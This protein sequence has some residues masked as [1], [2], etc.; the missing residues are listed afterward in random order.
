MTGREDI[1]A[2]AAKAFQTEPEHLWSQWPEHA[3]LRHAESG[4]WYGLIMTL[5]GSTLG[6]EGNAH[7]EVVNLKCRPCAGC[8]AAQPAGLGPA[9]ISYE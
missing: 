4:R 8:P 2:Y 6:L 3:V 9:R 1:L 5:P 7:V